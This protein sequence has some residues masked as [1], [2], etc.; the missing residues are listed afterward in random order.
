MRERERCIVGIFMGR[1][2]QKDI[3]V[4]ITSGGTTLSKQLMIWLLST[5]RA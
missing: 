3:V 1:E 2:F 5:Q 4:R